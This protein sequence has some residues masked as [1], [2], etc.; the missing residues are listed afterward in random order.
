MSEFLTRNAVLDSSPQRAF[1]FF[2][3]KKKLSP[4]PDFHQGK[5]S[6]NA[7]AKPDCLCRKWRI[8]R[9]IGC[10]AVAMSP[11]PAAAKMSL[12]KIQSVI[13]RSFGAASKREK[14]GMSAVPEK[15]RHTTPRFVAVFMNSFSVLAREI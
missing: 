7:L 11:A 9:P 12:I 5:K 1:S 3:L 10:T 13:W 6:G 14:G 2:F 15:T 4:V 8:S